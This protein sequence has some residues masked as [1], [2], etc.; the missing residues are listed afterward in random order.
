MSAPTSSSEN[1]FYF[2]YLSAGLETT[3]WCSSAANRKVTEMLQF[4]WREKGAEGKKIRERNGKKGKGKNEGEKGSG[5]ELG[6]TLGK[7]RNF[8][9]FSLGHN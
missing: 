3:K 7:Q 1:R 2:H 4:P 9:V 5:I 8:E 6:N